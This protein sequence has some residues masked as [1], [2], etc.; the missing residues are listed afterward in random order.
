M[1][2]SSN[3][4]VA[5]NNNKNGGGRCSNDGNMCSICITYTAVV[6]G[7]AHCHAHNKELTCYIVCVFFWGSNFSVLT[8]DDCAI[9]VVL[10]CGWCAMV[11]DTWCD[12]PCK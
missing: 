8:C 12:G 5:Y 6:R 4:T 10:G 1:V 9:E 2:L 11:A 7:V 3:L